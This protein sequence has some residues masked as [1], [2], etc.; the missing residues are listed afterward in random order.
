MSD[1][2]FSLNYGQRLYVRP[3]LM[4]NINEPGWFIQPRAQLNFVQYSDVH[5]TQ[6]AIAQGTYPN[7]SQLLLPILDVKTG[8]IFE[9]PTE[10]KNVNLM[11]TLEPTV[12]YLYVPISNKQNTLPNFDTQVNNFDYNQVFRDDRF[13]GYDR[14]AAANQ[15][16]LGLASKLFDQAS[17][18]EIAMLGIGQIRYITPNVVANIETGN[19]DQHWS[20][21][22]MV[23]KVRVAPKYTLEGNWIVDSESTKTASL[24]LQFR[25]DPTKVINFG[26]EYVRSTETDDMTGQ[27]QSNVKQLNI[28]AAWDLSSKF[29][30]LGKYTYDLIDKRDFYALGGVEYHTCCTALRLVV[31]RILQAQPSNNRNYINGFGIQFV[32]K[33]FTGVGTATDQE[34]ADLIPGYNADITTL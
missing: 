9:R 34:I 29:R 28:S 10:F 21:I 14:V 12:Y 18:E 17:G 31:N 16:G 15:L 2:N 7:R 13:A 11:Q 5:L 19:V 27:T 23:A 26:Y 25:A 30:V 33:G 4:Y 22:A 8:L 24:Q 6:T 20:P 32:F 3:A 1:N